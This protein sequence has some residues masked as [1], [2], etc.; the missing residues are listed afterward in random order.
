MNRVLKRY[1]LLSKLTVG[2]VYSWGDL[3]SL[4]GSL[5]RDLKQLQ[6]EGYLKRVGPGLYSLPK[7]SRFGDVPASAEQVVSAFLK[8]D[9]FLIFSPNLYNGLGLGLTQLKKQTFVYNKKRHGDLKLGNRTYEFKL[10][11]KG[12]P[13]DLTKEYLLVD[14]VNNLEDVGEDPRKL[15]NNVANSVQE[16]QF[17]NTKLFALA[18][19]YGHVYTKKFF[20][21]LEHGKQYPVKKVA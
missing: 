14:L 10:K 13:K 5:G 6:K 8:T 7:K 9:D 21:A 15:L 1:N 12:Y 17:D 16:N 4:S 20:V 19:Q 2:E 18:K 3:E 11:A